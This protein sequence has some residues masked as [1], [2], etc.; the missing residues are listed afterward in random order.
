[1]LRCW[2]TNGWW[3]IGGV[4]WLEDIGGI[5]RREGVNGIEGTRERSDQCLFITE[6]RL[7]FN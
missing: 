4:R 1:M 3:W 7:S 2:R 5:K 6:L